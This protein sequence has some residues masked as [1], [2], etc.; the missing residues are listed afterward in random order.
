MKLSEIVCSLLV[1]V[2]VGG[3]QTLGLIL[4]VLETGILGKAASGH[5]N[6][7]RRDT[8]KVRIRGRK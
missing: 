1:A 3:V 2:A 5:G 8:P 6:S 4:E 7:P